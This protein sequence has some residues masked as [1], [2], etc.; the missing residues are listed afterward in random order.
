[1]FVAFM[2]NPCP[3]IYIPT[4]IY[5]SIWFILICKI[6]LATNE[7]NS[8][9]T[10]KILMTHEHWPLQIYIWMIPQYL[11][12]SLILNSVQTLPNYLLNIKTYH[13]LICTCDHKCFE[14]TVIIKLGNTNDTERKQIFLFEAVLYCF[15]WYINFIMINWLRKFS[16]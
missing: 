1:M 16:Q 14:K 7:I 15:V 5:A 2:V 9:Q 3:R 10:K 13:I 11:I 4:N 12:I 8:L 6:T